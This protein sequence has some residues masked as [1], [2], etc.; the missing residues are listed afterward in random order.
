MNS[1]FAENQSQNSSA[2]KREQAQHFETGKTLEQN[3]NFLEFDSKSQ[4]LKSL[5]NLLEQETL[6][7]SQIERI[8]VQF[9]IKTKKW[10]K[11]LKSLESKK[12]T[13]SFSVNQ[14]KIYQELKQKLN[15]N[16]IFTTDTKI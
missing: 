7:F 12:R 9:V 6:D 4:E 13:K 10:E 14:N 3:I 5:R 15:N 1:N 16:E 11:E 8:F 2:L